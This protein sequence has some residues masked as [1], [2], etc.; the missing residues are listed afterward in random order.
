M[1][2][3]TNSYEVILVSKRRE[4]GIFFAVLDFFLGWLAYITIDLSPGQQQSPKEPELILI[5][6]SL[7]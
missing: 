6:E 3:P 1:G 5:Q 2:Q 4:L 7:D